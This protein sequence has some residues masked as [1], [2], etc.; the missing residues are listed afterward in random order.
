M[1]I[2]VMARLRTDSSIGGRTWTGAG[3]GGGAVGSVTITAFENPE[4]LFAGSIDVAPMNRPG[5]TAA[6]LKKIAALPS[7]P[8]VMVVSPRKIWPGP[9]PFGSGIAPA[10]NWMRYAVLGVPENEPWIVVM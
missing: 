6:V 8:V 5:L 4:V 7:R 2:C 3:A 9:R 10:K 1:T